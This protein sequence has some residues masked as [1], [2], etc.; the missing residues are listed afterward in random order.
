VVLT[1]LLDELFSPWMWVVFPLV[2]AVVYA[3]SAWAATT[4]SELGKS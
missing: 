4:L 2:A 3:F 1:V